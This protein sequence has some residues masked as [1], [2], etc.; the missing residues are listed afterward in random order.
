MA[1]RK[2]I[3]APEDFS[4][5]SE[6]AFRF[7]RRL[8]KNNHR[9]WFLPRKA[10]FE[11]ELQEPMMLLLQAIENEMKK[12]NLP[13]RMK[14][15]GMLSR[16]YRDVRFSANKDP[17]HTF[18]SGAL[19]RNGRKTA[20]GVLY[21]HMA[22]KE[23]FAAVGFWQPDRAALTSWRVRMQADPEAFFRM[24]K[25]L[26]NKNFSL[27]D[28]HLPRGF[29][30]TEGSPIGEY[31]RFQSFVIMRP[32]TKAEMTSPELPQLV[33]RFALDAKPLLDYGSKVPE[34]KPTVFLD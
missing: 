8:K 28:A 33:A 21:V 16:I 23:H 26:K 15:K 22:E 17:Y 2:Q 30:G 6:E 18:L 25:Q 31:L 19:F 20:P 9:D 27:D 29:E 34:E 32:I 3:P 10:T 4:G 13:L 12:N 24:I 11:K 7:L 5:F 14:P 1:P